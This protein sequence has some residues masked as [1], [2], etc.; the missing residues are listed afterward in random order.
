MFEDGD[1]LDEVATLDAN[2]LVSQEVLDD[3]VGHVLTEG[4]AITIE[5]MDCAEDELIVGYGSILT[6]HRLKTREENWESQFYWH[7]PYYWH[8]TVTDWGSDDYQ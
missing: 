8:V 2:F 1:L 3:D 7:V 5:A 6:T 4:V